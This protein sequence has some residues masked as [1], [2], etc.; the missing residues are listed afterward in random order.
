MPTI[1]GTPIS[2][3]QLLQGTQGEVLLEVSYRPDDTEAW[4]SRRLALPLSFFT[5]ESTGGEETPTLDLDELLG[6][7]QEVWL[8]ALKAL[9]TLS[10]SSTSG[11]VFLKD[12]GSFEIGELPEGSEP[13]TKESL[14]LD[15]VDNTSDKDKP[16]SD[17]TRAALAEKASTADLTEAT[18]GLL[19]QQALDAALQ[20]L[21]REED[22]VDALKDVLKKA[23]IVDTLTDASAI[24]PLS[25]R[26]GKLLKEQLDALG[27]VFGDD[28]DVDELSRLIQTLIDNKDALEKIQIDHIE[29]LR[30]LLTV[31]QEHDDN[32]DT[33]LEVVEGAVETLESKVASLEA[34]QEDQVDPSAEIAQ[35]HQEIEALETRQDGTDTDLTG[36]KARLTALEDNATEGGGIDPA[37]WSALQA[38]VDALVQQVPNDLGQELASLKQRLQALEDASSDPGETPPPEVDLSEIESRLDTLEAAIQDTVKKDGTKGLSTHDF[39]STF[40]NALQNLIDN[41]PTSGGGSSYTHPTGFAQNSVTDLTGRQVISGIHVNDEGHVERIDTRD[42]PETSGGEG[43]GNTEGGGKFVRKRIVIMRGELEGILHVVGFGTQDLID[44]VTATVNGDGSTLTLNN[45][46]DGLQ[47]Q[48][49][50]WFY[51]DGFNTTT[52]F[53]I[54]Y[55]DPFGDTFMGDMVLPTMLYYNRGNPPGIQPQVNISYGNTNGIA[56]IKRV[57]LINGYGYHFRCQFI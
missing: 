24:K 9:V 27:A 5:E 40:R 33:R 19:N 32:T 45:V 34:A 11:P 52:S 20:E 44:Q 47:L 54:E 6:V 21:M 1:T 57:G 14:G 37:D 30:D 31:L 3:M 18:R 13:V 46:P 55:P 22:L 23:D 35:L 2:K 28:M 36:L 4:K 10:Q 49:A 38:R 15:Q 29:G 41:P 25:A 50:S 17:A 42:L 48:Q 51:D 16:L 53:T 12:D 56:H 7:D 43:G 8:P 26:Q 39:T